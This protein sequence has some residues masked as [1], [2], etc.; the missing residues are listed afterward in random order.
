VRK[1]NLTKTNM[2]FGS[3]AICLQLASIVINWTLVAHQRHSGW[4]P[5]QQLSGFD[6]V[7]ELS[8][9]IL[10]IASV[11]M[12]VSGLSRDRRKLLAI[13]A[14]VLVLPI[15]MVIAGFQGYS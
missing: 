15:G 8:S 3:S 2:R 12:G 9:I 10:L 4:Q 1:M 5:S 14:L 6:R 7:L 13:I 11:P